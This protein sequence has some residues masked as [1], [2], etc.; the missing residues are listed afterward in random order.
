MNWSNMTI[1]FANEPLK[2]KVYQEFLVSKLLLNFVVNNPAALKAL[3][4]S[5]D[6]GGIVERANSSGL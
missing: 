5:T 6:V 1:C 4:F 3:S 2:S